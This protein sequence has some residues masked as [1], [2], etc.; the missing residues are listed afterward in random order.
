[1][2]PKAELAHAA[3]MALQ[4][5]EAK[6]IL[7]TALKADPNDPDL[8]CEQA[9]LDCF[10][11]RESAAAEI[12]DRTEEASRR[13]DLQTMLR[14]HYYCVHESDRH[15]RRAEKLYRRFHEGCRSPLDRV[16]IGIS[17]ILIVKNEEKLLP[18][19]LASLKGVVNQIVIVDTGSTDRTVEIARSYGATLGYFE[20][21]NDYAAA[22]NECL[23]LA[24]QPWALWIDADEELDPRGV[25]A[26]RRAVVRP[27]FGGY[28]TEI[29]NYT[30]DKAASNEFVHS[31]IRLFRN[32]PGV[33]FTERIHEQVGPSLVKLEMIWATIEGPCI[34]H[35][36]Y[37]PAEMEAK[38]KLDKTIALLEQ[39]VRE[40]PDDSFQWF[41]LANAHLIAKRFTEAEHGAE[42]C[43]RLIVGEKDFAPLAYQILA[44]ARSNQGDIEGCLRACDAADAARYGGILNE[45]ERASALA[46]ASR[47]EEALVAVNRCMSAPWPKGKP[48]DRGIFA[49]KRYILR[50]QILSAL[51]QYDEAQRMFDYA[52][53]VDIDNSAAIYSKAY[54]YERAQNYTQAKVWYKRGVL[55]PELRELS[56]QGI[57]RCLAHQGNHGEARDMFRQAWVADPKNFDKWRAWLGACEA[58]NDADQA[59]EAFEALAAHN[60]PNADVLIDWGRALDKAG[61]TNRALHNFSL[62]IEMDPR[63]ANAYF[64]CG[65]LLYRM[66]SFLDA[67]HL[68]QNGLRQDPENAEAWFTLGNSL[69]QLGLNEGAVTSYQQALNFSPNHRGALH[70]LEIVRMESPLFVRQAA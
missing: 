33:E 48:G 3:M 63:N 65:D 70:N 39:V 18:Q 7:Y 26:I 32:V 30:D 1:M 44:N 46:N 53:N 23:K 55:F 42:N 25:A 22:R 5:E 62:A 27:Q 54:T 15:D 34:K 59:L 36:G 51:E 28:F 14:N 57:A 17:A 2:H 19:C 66:G 31:A 35:H 21:I 40:Q 4:P 60:D 12:F 45:F 56:E 20:W 29:V 16:G 13:A 37:R 67:A 58:A 24:T 47:N 10:F 52:L 9:I 41:N 43:I 8:L 69:A 50:G 64:N 61:E 49:Y 68:Y 11:Q 6:G 38:G